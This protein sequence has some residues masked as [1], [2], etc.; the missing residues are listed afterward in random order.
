M[1]AFY[2]DASAKTD[3]A[4][5]SGYLTIDDIGNIRTRI[6]YFEVQVLDF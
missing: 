2:D 6:Y 5:A 1:M 4:I 3:I